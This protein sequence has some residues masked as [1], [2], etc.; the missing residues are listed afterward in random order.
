MNR[1]EEQTLALAAVFQTA[2]LVHNIASSGRYDDD[3]LQVC[4]QGI[5]NT[6]PDSVTDVFGPPAVLRTGLQTLINQLG[7]SAQTRKVEIARYVIALLHLQRKLDKNPAMLGQ[8]AEGIERARAQTEH[9]ALTHTN[10]LANLAGIYSDTVSHM[11]P[12]IMVNGEQQYLSNPDN[13]SRIRALLLAGIRAAV[14]WR[15][16]GGNR[17]QIL[18]K[19]K[20]IVDTAQQLLRQ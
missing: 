6:D 4:L 10:V 5:L 1:T 8:V 2:Q 3:D 11:T 19:R 12:K 13:V 7:A 15:Q 14:L 16:V 20:R 18:F 9:Y 17:W